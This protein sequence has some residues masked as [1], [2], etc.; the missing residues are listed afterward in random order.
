[1]TGI[2]K[3]FAHLTAICSLHEG[4]ASDLHAANEFA[5]CQLLLLIG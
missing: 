4:V 1:M 3:L 5:T 2:T